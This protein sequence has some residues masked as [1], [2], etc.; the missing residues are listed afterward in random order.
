M[1]NEAG[2]VELLGSEKVGKFMFADNN[3]F[4]DE[5]RNELV[6]IFDQVWDDMMENSDDPNESFGTYADM[7]F[8]LLKQK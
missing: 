4:N 7:K 3:V 1:A 2:L 6:E 5:I 8:D